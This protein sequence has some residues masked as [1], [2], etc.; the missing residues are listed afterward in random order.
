MLRTEQAHAGFESAGG[1]VAAENAVC[2]AEGLCALRA[3]R[4]DSV[5]GLVVIGDWLE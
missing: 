2:M 4:G 5:R 1:G 3:E